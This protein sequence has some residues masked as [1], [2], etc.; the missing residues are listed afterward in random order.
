MLVHAFRLS[1]GTRSHRDA[2]P[3]TDG[4]AASAGDHLGPLFPLIC[5]LSTSPLTTHVASIEMEKRKDSFSQRNG[6]E[7]GPHNNGVKATAL[8]APQSPARRVSADTRSLRA[9]SVQRSTST[10]IPDLASRLPLSPS[11]TAA[12][13][14]SP[15]SFNIGRSPSGGAYDSQGGAAT[16]LKRVASNVSMTGS[17]LRRQGN[18]AIDSKQQPM[19][20]DECQYEGV[21]SSPNP[22]TGLDSASSANQISTSSHVSEIPSRRT[23]S[24]RRELAAIASPPL[25]GRMSSSIAAWET[26]LHNSEAERAPAKSD[27][28]S[29]GQKRLISCANLEPG[30]SSRASVRRRTWYGWTISAKEQEKDA[31][32]ASTEVT[33]S[34]PS[35]D[36][37][38]ES[39]GLLATDAN[40]TA[41]QELAA[42]DKLESLHLKPPVANIPSKE[43]WNYKARR[44]WFDWSQPPQD[45]AHPASP[46]APT[47]KETVV[48]AA[49]RSETGYISTTLPTVVG[50]EAESET[51]RA[52]SDKLAVGKGSSSQ[53]VVNESSAFSESV[54]QPIEPLQPS[55]T[56]RFW[57]P[58]RHQDSSATTADPQPNSEVQQAQPASDGQLAEELAEPLSNSEVFVNNQK[59]GLSALSSG[60]WTR[61]FPS[62]GQSHSENFHDSSAETS[63]LTPAERVKA[64]ALA[65]SDMLPSAGRIGAL[66]VSS[67]MLNVATRQSWISYFASRNARPAQI[68]SKEPE[69][70]EI[71]FDESLNRPAST[72]RQSSANDK[73]EGFKT[74][75][76]PHTGK[77]V[78]PS[79]KIAGE[80]MSFAQSSRPTTP[81]LGT[82]LPKP[83]PTPSADRPIAP[84]TNSKSKDVEA[85]KKDAK[86]SSSLRP[87]LPNLVLPTFDDSFLKQPRSQ[88]PPA[89]VLKRTLIAVNTWLSG[90]SDF[91]RLQTVPRG[92]RDGS[93]S[94]DPGHALA[95][96]A[97]IRLP[98][99]W[100][101]MGCRTKGDRKGCDPKIRCIVTIG[102]HGWFAQSWAS[103]WMGEP[104]GTSNKFATQMRDAVLRHFSSVDGMKLNSEAITMIPLSA[105]G[106]VS[107]RVDQSFAALLSRKE[108]VQN[109]READAILFACH[110]QGCIVGANLLARLIEQKLINPRQ[111]RL[112]VLAMCGVHAGP[113]EHL[114]TTV[115]SSYLNYFETA[116][117]KE[118]FEFQKS[119]SPV[120]K[121]Y[122]H[123]LK[124]IL[125]AG[126]K[127][128]LVAST[129]DQ[130]VPLHSAL[131]TPATHPSILRALYIHGNTFPR[132]DFLTN[133]L[134]FCVG[135]RNA[136][137][138]D[139]DLLAL[140][141]ASVAGSL[142]GG[143]GHSLCYDERKTYDLAVQ[144][145]FQTTHPLSEPT[146]RSN[147]HAPPQLKLE[148]F[149][150]RKFNN[151]HLLPWSLRGILEDRAVC[152]IFAHEINKLLDDFE[153]WKPS[154][155]TLKDVQ[156]RLE[157]MRRVPRPPKAN[158][159]VQNA[160]QLAI[161]SKSTTSPSSSK[162]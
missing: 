34:S 94:S 158:T 112:A 153:S 110:S 157:P 131:F 45:N 39:S 147:E 41:S 159:E 161:E 65:R 69:V 58:A 81:L 76:A 32:V 90:P 26:T 91:S 126:A 5:P 143:Q 74:Q 31:L 129:D 148:S 82:R 1:S 118:L 21:P 27:I 52:S 53:R 146:T 33:L 24:P 30:I 113:F 154:T 29:Y 46:P 20:Y 61:W 85:I 109:L 122:E 130:V 152:A 79:A 151:P 86:K 48:D 116:A 162:L 55:W 11:A 136:G 16:R 56:W 160:Q 40:G 18:A 42:V 72:D 49:Q 44:S 105:D 123:S 84:L 68:E 25:D 70:M 83:D 142:Y 66:N 78:P 89:G 10:V 28:A 3:A 62:W 63:T 134:T 156:Y 132:L 80:G 54:I 115:V 88:A 4:Q 100:K 6:S 87:P 106:T 121:R 77:A 96:E 14:A 120:S 144:Y 59:Q 73:D 9:P 125:D 133:M 119:T 127:M 92:R 98:R 93:C 95:E 138:W 102:I 114:R 12:L 35:S 15:H 17:L 7:L 43:S 103:K 57:A 137:L 19:Q 36:V 50:H 145:L 107:V 51:I 22:P 75:S 67:A 64:A 108:W 71:D 37:D 128:L 135:V 124:V 111:T 13:S 149:E 140:L 97:S 23:R 141:S 155:K 8:E 104:T 2:K 99:T 60:S 38:V 117:A 101:T 150:T 47:L 139:H